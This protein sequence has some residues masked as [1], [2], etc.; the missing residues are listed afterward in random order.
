MRAIFPESPNYRNNSLI[1]YDMSNTKKLILRKYNPRLKR[2]S[3][4]PART[5]HSTRRTLRTLTAT[6]N[7]NPNP[8]TPAR[9]TSVGTS[10][11][12]GPTWEMHPPIRDSTHAASPQHVVRS[13]QDQP[14]NAARLTRERSTLT[15][16]YVQ[17]ARHRTS[18]GRVTL[19]SAVILPD[20]SRA[21]DI[22][23]RRP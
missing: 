3:T 6:Y 11:S 16:L 9:R 8:S 17:G 12:R 2:H 20:E 13:T 23:R 19:P 4:L 1:A 21:C 22:L 15:G 10:R 14:G 7:F 5:C 18:S